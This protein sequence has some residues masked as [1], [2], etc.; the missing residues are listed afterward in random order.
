MMYTKSH[1]KNKKNES[2]KERITVPMKLL[3]YMNRSI[4]TI[5]SWVNLR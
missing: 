1:K 2:H 5:T 3:N 4:A